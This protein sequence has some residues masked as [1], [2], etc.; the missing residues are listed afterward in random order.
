MKTNRATKGILSYSLAFTY[1]ITQDACIWHTLLFD[2]K[3]W[4]EGCYDSFYSARLNRSFP[5]KWKI[6]SY[7][8]NDFE[9]GKNFLFWQ[10]KAK[11]SDNL[12]FE[13]VCKSKILYKGHTLTYT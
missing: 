2:E 7:I 10:K 3:Q 6:N 4:S 13:R 11:I 5:K 9:T 1:N 8:N 12:H